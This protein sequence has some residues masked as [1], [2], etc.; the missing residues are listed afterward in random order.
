MCIFFTT[1]TPPGQKS[2]SNSACM[3]LHNLLLLP[4]VQYVLTVEVELQCI[5]GYLLLLQGEN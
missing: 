1:R 3:W 5:L 4:V 2:Y